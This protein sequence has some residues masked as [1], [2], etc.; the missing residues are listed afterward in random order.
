MSREPESSR[1]SFGVRSHEKVAMRTNA[2]A[3]AVWSGGVRRKCEELREHNWGIGILPGSLR[4]GENAYCPAGMSGEKTEGIPTWGAA[5]GV[6]QLPTRCM[7]TAMSSTPSR[8]HIGGSAATTWSPADGTALTALL[9]GGSLQCG[10]TIQ[11]TAGQTYINLSS[12]FTFPAPACDGNHWIIV[13]S[14][15]VANANFP[16]EGVRAT[17]CILG[18]ANDATH[19]RQVPDGAFQAARGPVTLTIAAEGALLQRN[20]EDS[21][22]AMAVLP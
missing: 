20:D 18:L 4:V 3:S 6:A 16:A 13:K 21:S 10:D 1:H 14:S 8:T 22:A 17:P 9:N 7:N 15:G 5:D 12:A 19:G 2:V 11:L